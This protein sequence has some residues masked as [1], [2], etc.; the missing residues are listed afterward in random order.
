M[1]AV[2][3]LKSK[4]KHFVIGEAEAYW[5]PFTF[6]AREGF[7]T[8]PTW[9]HWPVATLPNDG[10]VAPTADR[11]SSSCFGT[12]YPV[13]HKSDKPNMMTGRNLYGMTEKSAEELAVLARSWNSPSPIKVFGDGFE[14]KG[15]D[16]NQ[17]AYIIWNDKTEESRKIQIILEGSEES[18][19]L[20]PAFVIGNWNSCD[21]SLKVDGKTVAQGENLRIGKLNT[22]EGPK[23][24]V[25]VKSESN[26]TINLELESK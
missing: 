8:I 6:G 11:P 19:V 20:N 9:N 25:W 1:I 15:F 3:N 2:M 22:L 10:R 12:L 21:F 5:K 17:R 4:Q 16:M 14:S 18:P 23:L 13:K 24:I 7:S 26:T